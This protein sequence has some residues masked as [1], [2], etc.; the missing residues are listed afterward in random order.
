VLDPRR[1]GLQP[2]F[3]AGTCRARCDIWVLSPKMPFGG[4]LSTN[5][6]APCC[7]SRVVGGAADH[8]SAGCRGARHRTGHRHV[9]SRRLGN[10]RTRTRSAGLRA[11][12][13]VWEVAARPSWLGQGGASGFRAH[14]R[15]V[16]GGSALPGVRRAYA[17]ARHSDRVS[18]GSAR[19]GPPA[20]R[21]LR[22]G[23]G[24]LRASEAGTQHES[25]RLVTS[26]AF[27]NTSGTFAAPLGPFV[28]GLRVP[29]AT[30]RRR[31]GGR[32]GERGV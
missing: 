23:R 20:A 22:G 12:N 5:A 4:A 24:V 18:M 8:T 26:P 3:T 7:W 32:L 6:G 25:I 2:R 19:G 17:T 14:D 30:T 31:I 11:G 21:G 28:H 16:P 1:Q 9:S 15:F 29:A 13:E 10:G 27:P